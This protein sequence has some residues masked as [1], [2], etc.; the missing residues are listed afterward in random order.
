MHQVDNHFCNRLGPRRV[1]RLLAV[2]TLL[3]AGTATAAVEL[4]TSVKRVV[5]LVT[6]D[7]GPETLLLSALSVQPGQELRYTIAFTNAGSEFIDPGVI[8]ITNPIPETAEY[9]DGTAT[10]ADT[11]I[12]FSVDG[13]ASFASAARLTVVENGA[14]VPATAAHYTTLRFTYGGILG[15]GEGSVVAFDVRLL[16]ETP[17]ADPGRTGTGH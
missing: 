7:G 6:D 9:L 13:G 11:E 12:E 15:P 14:R 17:P 2:A 4:S 3:L 10:G 1:R 16:E 5:R 8:V